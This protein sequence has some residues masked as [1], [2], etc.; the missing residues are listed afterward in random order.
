MDFV[1]IWK[2]SQWG[3]SSESSIMKNGTSWDGSNSGPPRIAKRWSA[4]KGR[5]V[6]VDLVGGSKWITLQLV[7]SN[8]D[9]FPQSA[10][11]WPTVLVLGENVWPTKSWMVTLGLDDISWL[12]IFWPTVLGLDGI[13]WL[14]TSQPGIQVLFWIIIFPAKL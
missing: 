11:F 5:M 10:K 1:R 13:S 7:T 8:L 2:C 14:A 9:D 4:G 6:K 12:A 3:L